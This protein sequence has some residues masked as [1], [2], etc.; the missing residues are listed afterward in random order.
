MALNDLIVYNLSSHQTRKVLMHNELSSFFSIGA[1]IFFF[2][3]LKAISVAPR[4]ILYS[5]L[6]QGHFSL[7]TILGFK[8]KDSICLL[9][10]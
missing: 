2:L 6:C 5:K 3:A 7:M 4:G 9:G 10:G 1:W 8:G